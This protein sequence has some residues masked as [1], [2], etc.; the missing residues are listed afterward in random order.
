MGLA[1]KFQKALKLYG[2]AQKMKVTNTIIKGI[3]IFVRG[4]KFFVNMVIKGGTG[5]KGESWFSAIN[6]FAK[7]YLGFSR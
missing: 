1:H 7:K 2:L 6:R 4:F 5:T 3:G